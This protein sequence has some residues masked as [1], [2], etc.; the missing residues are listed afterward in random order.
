MTIYQTQTCVTAQASQSS[1][2]S[3]SLKPLRGEN[4]RSNYNKPRNTKIL[5]INFKR[6][7]IAL[8]FF[9]FCIWL[10]SL[11][12][13]AIFRD[14]CHHLNAAASPLCALLIN[15]DLI[16][17]YNSGKF[18]IRDIIKLGYFQSRNFHCTKLGK[19]MRFRDSSAYGININAQ[20]RSVVMNTCWMLRKL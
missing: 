1:S 9:Y 3:S 19:C 4:G 11:F 10:L 14:R 16:F 6:R 15:R 17:E 20:V 18:I 2:S 13:R 12:C 8:I 7:Q 5:A